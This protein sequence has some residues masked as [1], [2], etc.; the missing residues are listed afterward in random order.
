MGKERIFVLTD[1]RNST[2][3][4]LRYPPRLPGKFLE[5]ALQLLSEGSTSPQAQGES[6][7]QPGWM[8]ETP[9]HPHRT[10]AT[11]QGCSMKRGCAGNDKGN[12]FLMPCNTFEA[13]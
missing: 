5:R 4:D 12:V 2:L 1:A 8:V 10:Q 3:W 11:F 6:L 13:N 7:G 9:S